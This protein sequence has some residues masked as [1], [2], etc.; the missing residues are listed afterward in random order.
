MP[1][2]SLLRV[3]R[4]VPLEPEETAKRVWVSYRQPSAG[5]GAEKATAKL[6][7]GLFFMILDRLDIRESGDV[8]GEPIRTKQ[9]D[10]MTSQGG[11]LEMWYYGNMAPEPGGGY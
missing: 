2:A 4:V 11:S 9:P 5:P 6:V 8:R 7:D 3:E 10:T 1:P